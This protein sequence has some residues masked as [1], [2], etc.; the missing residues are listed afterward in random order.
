VG[1]LDGWRHCPVC[2]TAVEPESGRFECPEC[3]FVAFAHSMPTASAV[4]DDGRGAV[5]LSR[6][7]HDPAAGKWDL[8]GGFLEEGEH[9]LD[10]VRRELREEAGI[11]L[12]DEEL[13]GIWMDR[14][15]YRGRDVAT[16]NVYYGA[17]V[18]DG[19]PE[20]SDDVAELRWFRLDEIPVADLAFEHI[21]D[22]LSTWRMRHE[23][24]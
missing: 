9:P 11:S 19:T 3:G 13:L 1:E 24:A 21:T 20:P 8:P 17:R 22:V 2:A 16:V 7:A 23:D 4:V 12:A 5:L 15:E 10:C 6:R 14:Y 18:A